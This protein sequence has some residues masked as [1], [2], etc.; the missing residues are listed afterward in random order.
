MASS[1]LRQAVQHAVGWGS[2]MGNANHERCKLKLISIQQCPYTP[3]CVFLG[4]SAA[5]SAAEKAAARKTAEASQEGSQGRQ[6]GRQ[7]GGQ[8]GSK[9]GSQGSSAAEQAKGALSLG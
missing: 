6:E 5:A 9:T 2:A 4:P 7:E 3:K 1:V 8:E